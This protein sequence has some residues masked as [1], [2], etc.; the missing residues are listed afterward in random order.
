M[1]MSI[2]SEIITQISNFISS[3]MSSPRGYFVIFLLMIL[4]SMVFPVP[5]ELVMPFAGFIAAKGE[6]NLILVIVFSTIGS[7]TGSLISYYIGKRWGIKLIESYGKYILVDTDDLKKTE[8]W[9]K[10]R[11]EPTIFASRLIPVVRHLISLVAGVGKMN[12]KKFSIYTI[13]GAAIWNALLA[14]LGYLLGQ[15]WKQVTGYTDELSIVV[16]IL[17]VIGCIYYI[18]R[19]LTKKKK[20][21]KTK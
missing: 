13:A 8:A 16:V 4:E 19:H 15:N 21:V 2:I 10:K 14:Y 1:N 3:T 11:G 6:L 12:I 17:L 9:F 5:S 18:Y 7:I 20:H